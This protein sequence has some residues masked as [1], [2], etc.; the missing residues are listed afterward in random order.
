LRRRV[1]GCAR[2]DGAQLAGELLCALIAGTSER[3][4]PPSLPATHLGEDVRRVP[5]AVEAHAAGVPAQAQ[6]PVAD[7]PGAHQR[8]CLLAGVAVGDLKAEPRV[9]DRVLGEAAVDVAPGEPG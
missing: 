3:V 5:E 9:G 2:P 8:R 7:Q 4:Y 1:L 6:R